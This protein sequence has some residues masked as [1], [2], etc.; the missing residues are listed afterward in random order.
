MLK[1]AYPNALK[2][3]QTALNQTK[4]LTIRKIGRPASDTG[5]KCEGFGRKGGGDG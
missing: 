1:I 4:H 2:E 3:D 5:R